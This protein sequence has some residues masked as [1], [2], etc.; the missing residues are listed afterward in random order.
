MSID[1][2]ICVSSV[3]S[4]IA[5]YAGGAKRIE[6]CS[7]LSEG[8]VTPSAGLIDAVRAAVAMD[9]FLIIRPRGGD[10]V[11]SDREFDV[12][13]KDI[14]E[15]K[16]RGVDGAVL[17]VL[18]RTGNVDV[19]RTKELIELARPLEVTF[20]R[21]FD[22]CKDLDRALEDV[23]ACGARRILTSGGEADA[24]RGA[25]RIAQLRERAG[26]RI[27]IMA[28][29]GIRGWNVEQLARQTGIREIHSSLS[30]GADPAVSDGIQHTHQNGGIE[31]RVLDA[32]VRAF[33]AVLDSI[34]F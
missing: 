12:M 19:A 27:G 23:V 33:K 28:G 25:R 29:G 14:I 20:H 1:L 2:E 22:L 5:A 18:T 31:F 8:G 10:F 3:E 4:A 32:D 13:R 7:A 26:D 16:T 11:Y 24:L 17:G 6:L 30:N 9:V 34:T 15:A 21:A